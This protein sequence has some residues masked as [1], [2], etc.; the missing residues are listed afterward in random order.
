M[1]I[2]NASAEV[3][4]TLQ[5]RTLIAVHQLQR[6]AENATPINAAQAVDIDAACVALMAAL[7]AAGYGTTLP[8]TQAVVSDGNTVP[9]EGTGTTATLVVTGGNLVKVTLA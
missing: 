9:A 6:F 4:L 2:E 1:T 8:P 5:R 3:Q 7:D